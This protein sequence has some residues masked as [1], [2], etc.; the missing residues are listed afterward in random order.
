MRSFFFGLI[1]LLVVAAA[2]TSVSRF[3]STARVSATPMALTMRD[4]VQLYALLYLPILLPWDTC[5]TV[6]VRTPYGTDTE[7]TFCQW[8]ANEGNACI[9]ADER[10][11][12]FESCGATSLC[13]M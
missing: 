10:G 1:M 7:T 11:F 12:D 4:G 8:M 5:G 9:L 3:T 2:S 6:L 13:Y